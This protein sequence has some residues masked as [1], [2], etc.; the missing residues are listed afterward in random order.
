MEFSED[1]EFLNRLNNKDKLRNSEKYKHKI[2]T[3]GI[4]L[5]KIE[6]KEM[7]NDTREM[8]N[9]NRLENVNII[10]II[11]TARGCI[12]RKRFVQQAFATDLSKIEMTKPVAPIA[13]K[14]GI[15]F[16]NKSAPARY[17]AHMQIS[18]TCHYRAAFYLT[19]S[20]E[21][22]NHSRGPS[23][24][25]TVNS[26]STAFFSMARAIGESIEI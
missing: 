2:V 5:P 21:L 24:V 4:V 13:R 16:L 22:T 1:I 10:A 7:L 3:W 9:R 23:G 25:F 15:L 26:S 6:S 12:M 17:V 20:I 14:R 8:I 19:Y 18:S 11:E